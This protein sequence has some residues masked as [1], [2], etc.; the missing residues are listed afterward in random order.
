MA[1]DPCAFYRRIFSRKISPLFSLFVFGRMY[2]L[3]VALAYASTLFHLALIISLC[4]VFFRVF[5]FMFNLMSVCNASLNNIIRSK[6]YKKFGE[7]F[8]VKR[9]ETSAHA[10]CGPVITIENGRYESTYTKHLSNGIKVPP[11]YG[12]KRKKLTGGLWKRAVT[13]FEMKC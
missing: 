9:T 6:P 1:W 13:R 10:Y 8:C 7:S 4:K 11:R 5:S 12:E 2:L 3:V